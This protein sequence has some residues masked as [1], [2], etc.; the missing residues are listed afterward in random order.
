MASRRRAVTRA[1]R[2]RRRRR[3][4]ELQLARTSRKTDL[5]ENRNGHLVEL[6][7]LYTL[8]C[9]VLTFD[10]DFGDLS[11]CQGT[12]WPNCGHRSPVDG[13]LLRVDGREFTDVVLETQKGWGDDFPSM[14]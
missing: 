2:H 3:R 11:C 9:R 5:F 4:R 1:D 13:A 8:V 7:E 6:D 12:I 14:R 10:D